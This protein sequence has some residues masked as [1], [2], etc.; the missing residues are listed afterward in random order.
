MKIYLATWIHEVS[1]KKELDKLCKRE[2][3]VFLSHSSFPFPPY[4]AY[5]F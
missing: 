3:D 4:L 5:I 2:I 1:Q